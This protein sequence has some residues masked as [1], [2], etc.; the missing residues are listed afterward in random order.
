MDRRRA[1]QR[2]SS[3]A[4]L[5]ASLIERDRD[6]TRILDDLDKIAKSLR[7]GQ[8]DPQALHQTLHRTVMCAIKQSLLDRELRSLALSDHLTG[9]YS[10]RAFYALAAQ[11]L[12][13]MRRKSQ[14]LL[15][16]FADVD[17]LKE[18]ND[19]FGHREGDLALTRVGKAL[20]ETFR[21]S[22]IVARL[23]GD[24][25]AVMALEASG[26]DTQAILNRLVRHLQDASAGER[27]Y[28]L[29]VSVGTSR[30]DPRN[31]AS[32][33]D[34]LANADNAMY[35]EKRSRNRGRSRRRASATGLDAR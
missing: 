30:F 8:L 34:L 9:L 12:R 11:Q 13:L 24:E 21:S 1:D 32:L 23:G 27:R 4:N 28:T 3:D 20:R 29:S 16:F 7:S 19:R 26:E 17:N 15:V 2:R 35:E 6:L 33:D 18:I 5:M 25:F 14:G 10:R 22:D 31:S